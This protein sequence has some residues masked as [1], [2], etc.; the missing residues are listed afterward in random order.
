[1]DVID[2]DK[3][4]EHFRVIYDHKGRFV[5]H[6]ITKEEAAYKICK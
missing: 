6:R 2:I 3:T 5:M 4:D 1:M